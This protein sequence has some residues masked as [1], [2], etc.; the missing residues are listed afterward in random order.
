[1]ATRRKDPMFFTGSKAGHRPIT[2]RI[3]GLKPDPDFL[4]LS[5]TGS[6]KRAVTGETD[7]KPG[8]RRHQRSAIHQF[9]HNRICTLK[10]NQ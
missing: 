3:N 6:E 1:M 2:N 10:S 9:H 5:R 4:T 8:S 7:G